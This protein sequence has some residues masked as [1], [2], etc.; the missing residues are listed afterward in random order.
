MSDDPYAAVTPAPSRRVHSDD[1][2]HGGEM[3]PARGGVTA[4]VDAQP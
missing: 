2:E 3:P 4:W 1:F